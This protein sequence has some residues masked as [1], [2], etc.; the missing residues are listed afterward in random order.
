MKNNDVNIQE[1]NL[2]KS[3]RYENLVITEHNHIAHAASLA[4]AEYPGEIYNP[5]YI[6]GATGVGKTYML[7][8]IGNYIVENHPEKMVYYT[9]GQMITEEII[10]ALKKQDVTMKELRDKY[11]AIDVLLVDDIQFM[12]GKEYTQMEFLHIVKGMCEC[13]KQIVVSCDSPLNY[14]EALH[15]KMQSFFA[16]GLVEEITLPDLEANKEFLLSCFEKEYGENIIS[17]EVVEY[18]SHN[19]EANYYVV[20][21]LLKKIIARSKDSDKPIDILTVKEMIK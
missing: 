6:Y 11:S 3:Y 14:K 20:K 16:S 1:T 9:T 5:F 15:D 18:V 21:G 2:N 12:M 8:A 13:G 7:H 19:V 17:M 4:V 10:E